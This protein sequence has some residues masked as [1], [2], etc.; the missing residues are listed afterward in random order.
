MPHLLMDG[1][2]KINSRRTLG[3]IF[4]ISFRSDSHNMTTGTLRK[5]FYFR[6]QFLTYTSPSRSNS[7]LCDQ[8]HCFCEYDHIEGPYRG[9]ERTHVQRTVS[10][11]PR[12][13]DIIIYFTKCA[14][15]AM[16]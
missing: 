6:Q 2:S 4:N 15:Y 1:I 14:P 8:V 7:M 16:H 12:G 3:Q 9:L 13:S 11:R 10:I 5:W